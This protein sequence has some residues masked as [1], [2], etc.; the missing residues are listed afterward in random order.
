[1]Q[2]LEVKNLFEC[3]CRTFWGMA[4]G[5][6]RAGLGIVMDWGLWV[7]LFFLGWW[8]CC[9]CDVLSPFSKFSPWCRFLSLVPTSLLLLGL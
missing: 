9:C 8:L 1:M 6:G 5:G 2:G 7:G 3:V 4:G